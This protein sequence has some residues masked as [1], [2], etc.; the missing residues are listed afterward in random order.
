M[1]IRT[2]VYTLFL[3]AGGALF[4]VPGPAFA[5]KTDVVVVKKGGK[6]IGEIKRPPVWKTAAEHLGDEHCL[7]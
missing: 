6:I 2:I 1:S 7:Y 4:A 5:Q 3:S